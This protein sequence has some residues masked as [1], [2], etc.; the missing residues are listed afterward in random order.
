[1]SKIHN[2]CDQKPSQLLICQDFWLKQIANYNIQQSG[3]VW[4]DDKK[5]G[6]SIKFLIWYPILKS[7]S[8]S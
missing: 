8:L 2:Y 6:T 5:A 1:M 7:S 3:A 4:V